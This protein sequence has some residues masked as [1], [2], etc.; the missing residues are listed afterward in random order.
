MTCETESG[1]AVSKEPS[2]PFNIPRIEIDSSNQAPYTVKSCKFK[3]L[4]T[5]NFI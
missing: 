1:D 5:W 2:L 3:L 4:G